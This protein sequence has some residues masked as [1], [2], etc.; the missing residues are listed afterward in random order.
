LE[1]P[2]LSLNEALEKPDS[3]SFPA[4]GS[5]NFCAGHQP[6]DY[7][8]SDVQASV[9]ADFMV[10]VP[11]LLDSCGQLPVIRQLLN[12]VPQ[13]VSLPLALHFLLASQ[14]E[15][16]QSPRGTTNVTEHR[17]RRRHPVAV[18]LFT[19]RAFH[20]VFHPEGVVWLAIVL[21]GERDLS[22]GTFA[23]VG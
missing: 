17:F 10:S 22:S 4:S 3:E 20:P 12:I 14:A 6:A 9:F 5:Q 15:A 7:C 8:H 19:L 23:M 21:D 13:A 18:N 2:E 1:F 11:V 16:I